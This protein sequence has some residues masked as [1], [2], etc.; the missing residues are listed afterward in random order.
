MKRSSKTRSIK[1]YPNGENYAP[2]APKS[3]LEDHHESIENSFTN[4]E[5]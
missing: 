4:D 5:I 1:F 3:R 2:Y